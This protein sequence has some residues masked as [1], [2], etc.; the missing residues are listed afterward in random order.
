[1]RLKLYRG[2]WAAIWSEGGKTKRVSLRT[3]DRGTAERRLR[4]Q[5]KRPVGDTVGEIVASYLEEKKGQARS[6]DAMRFSWQAAKPMFGHLRPDQITR[7]LCRDYAT[8]RRKRGISNGTIIRDL[9]MVRAALNWAKKGGSADFELPHAPP[10]RERYLSREE[11]DRLLGACKMAHIELFV[12]LALATA[13]RASAVLELTWDR[14]DFDRGQI[15]LAKGEGNRKGRATVP[16]TDRARAAL[17]RAF[18]ARTTENV[19]EWAGGPV[20]SVKRAFREICE[21][22]G[23]KDVTPH[24]LRH[25]AAV[26]MVEAGNSIDEVAQFLGH[27]DSRITY[28]VYGRFSPDYL[29]KAARALE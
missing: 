7:K 26:W 8:Q 5:L 28:R 19:I 13:G 4:D 6:H 3:S 23:L 9:G 14:I 25:T 12:I 18:E 15:R 29:R 21:R 27:T 22:A 10:P 24:V 16:M 20:K 17:L 1:M 2:K 11:Y